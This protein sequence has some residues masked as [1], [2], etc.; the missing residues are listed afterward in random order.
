MTG[1]SALTLLGSIAVLTAV[2]CGG[3]APAPA[4]V[5]S[6]ERGDAETDKDLVIAEP[7]TIEEAEGQIARARASLEGTS[8]AAESSAPRAE[9]A[10]SSDVA[11]EEKAVDTC[12]SPCR[13]LA[14][15]KRAVEALCRMTG[16]SDTRCVDAK[17]TLDE[18]GHR[19]ATCRC[20]V[21]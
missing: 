16:E 8:K 11:R 20:D 4:K 10:P 6:P 18:S 14:S 15:M 13:A 17:R 3:A 1:K 19:V 12:G 5:Q 2:A 9:K 7:R 21:R